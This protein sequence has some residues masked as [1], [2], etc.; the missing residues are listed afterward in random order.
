MRA[1]GLLECVVMVVLLVKSFFFK[2][3]LAQNPAF[4]FISPTRRSGLSESG[5][6]GKVPGQ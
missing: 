3:Y 6:E 4:L 2:L 1:W 5:L